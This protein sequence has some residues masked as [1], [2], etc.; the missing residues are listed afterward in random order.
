[1]MTD[2]FD[3]SSA[4]NL[5][6]LYLDGDIYPLAWTSGTTPPGQGPG[7]LNA[8]DLPSLDYALYLFDTVRFRLGQGYRFFFEPD[9]FISGMRRYYATRSSDDAVVTEH[10]PRFWVVQFLMVLALGNA[11]LARP[12]NQKDPPGSKY[13]VR[14]MAAMPPFT[15]TGKDSLL[16][17]EALA[18]VSLYLYAIDHR[19]AAHVHVSF[20]CSDYPSTTTNLGGNRSDK[21]FESPNWKGYTR[22]SPKKY[23]APRQSPGAGNS[24]GHCTL[25]TATCR[26]RWGFHLLRGT[27][28]SRP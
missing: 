9:L 5:P 19:E 25:S 11:F 22:S 26:R 24:G 20:R 3:Q 17:I 8:G 14:A 28:T 21:R 1:M 12:R 23:W 16:A 15:S 10:Q 7:P 4:H 6:Q 13:F 2:R 27:A 18:L